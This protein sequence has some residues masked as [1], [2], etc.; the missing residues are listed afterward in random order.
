MNQTQ[1]DKLFEIFKTEITDD[2]ETNVKG[3]FTFRVYSSS[4]STKIVI[5]CYSKDKEQMFYTIDYLNQKYLPDCSGINYDGDEERFS[6][7]CETNSYPPN[8]FY[9]LDRQLTNELNTYFNAQ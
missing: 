9:T 4:D 3:P 5:R 2:S 6:L 1:K 8:I 7:G